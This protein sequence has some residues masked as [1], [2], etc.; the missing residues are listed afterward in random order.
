MQSPNAIKEVIDVFD[1]LKLK[2]FGM[3]ANIVSKYWLEKC[4]HNKCQEANFIHIYP[5]SIFKTGQWTNRKNG[6]FIAKP[7]TGNSLK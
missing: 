5:K 3:A 7:W 1:L 6:K 2:I 4:P